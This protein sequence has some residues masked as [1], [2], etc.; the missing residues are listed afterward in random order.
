MARRKTQNTTKKVVN[1]SVSQTSFM[2]QEV[3]EKPKTKD[4]EIPF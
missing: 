3:M 2:E 4:D 1:E